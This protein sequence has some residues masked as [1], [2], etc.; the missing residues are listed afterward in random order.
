MKFFINAFQTTIFLL[1]LSFQSAFPQQTPPEIEWE[2]TFG[3]KSNDTANSIVSTPDGGYAV[4]GYTKS[5]GTGEGALWV[6]KLDARDNL[7][8]DKTFGGGRGLDNANSIVSTPDGGYAVAGYTSSKGAGSRDLWILKLNAHGN[9]LWDKTFGGRNEDMAESIILT[10]DGGYAV[11]GH[12]SSKG[13]GV[14]DFW[15]LKLDANGIL[16]WER[17]FGGSGNDRAN[18]IVLTPD[19]GYAV[20]GHTRSKG[21]GGSD[22]WVLKLDANGSLLW[23]KTFGGFLGDFAKSIV[24]T[25]DG[26]YAVAGYTS[27][28][29]AGGSDFWVLKLDANGSLLWEKTFG[30]SNSDAAYTIIS[31]PDGGYAVT[32]YTFSKGAGGSDIWVLKLGARGNLLWDKTFGGSDYDNAESIILTPDGGFAVAGYTWSK[33]AGGSDLWVLKFDAR[34]SK[35]NT[36]KVWPLHLGEIEEIIA[37]KN[38]ERAKKAVHFYVLGLKNVFIP[39]PIPEK[40]RNLDDLRKPKGEFEKEAMYRQRLKE[41]D[42]EELRIKADYERQVEEARLAFDKRQTEVRRKVESLLTITREDI[43]VTFD[44]GKYNAEEETFPIFVEGF[45]SSVF[46]IVPISDAPDFKSRAKELKATVT[47]QMNMEGEK[48]YLNLYVTD[49]GVDKIYN[50]VTGADGTLA[51]LEERQVEKTRQARK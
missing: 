5:K 25:S 51:F 4:A 34:G 49:P 8:W 11:A 19:G 10:P 23:E 38:K 26:G 31:T 20:A 6:L 21:A 27:S 12:T 9:L 28:K 18:S 16:L 47:T 45:S 7:L 41:A 50:A 17:T 44:I 43:S 1:V 36:V 39:P 3:G 22:F 14:G 13:A 29:G 2:K 46:L 42:S 48:D 35:D 33:G 32:G 15:V 40:E 30:G 37:T 24:S